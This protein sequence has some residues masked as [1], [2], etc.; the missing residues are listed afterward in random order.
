MPVMRNVHLISVQ[1]GHFWNHCSSLTRFLTAAIA[2]GIYAFMHFLHGW[3]QVHP[4]ECAC[5]G[6]I[7][8]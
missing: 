3:R 5:M 4:L 7:Q 8:G 2:F 1:P 6:G